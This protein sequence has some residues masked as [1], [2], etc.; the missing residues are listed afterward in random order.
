M[1]SIIVSWPTVQAW[2]GFWTCPPVKLGQSSAS[3]SVLLRSFFAR[4]QHEWRGPNQTLDHNMNACKLH[5]YNP[6][7]NVKMFWVGVISHLAG[8][9][10]IKYL[11]LIRWETTSRPLQDCEPVLHWSWNRVV[12]A[13]KCSWV[14]DSVGIKINDDVLSKLWTIKWM[15]VNCASC[16]SLP[17]LAHKW[18][19]PFTIVEG[20]NKR[21]GATTGF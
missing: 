11:H 7:K 4:H 6:P 1:R 9:V 16:P 2:P 20:K 17:H 5:M 14:P 8:W 10:K 3:L 12:T 15:P 19:Q 18:C 13:Q 21:F